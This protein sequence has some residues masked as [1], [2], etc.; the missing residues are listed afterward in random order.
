M[1]T[2]P[3]VLSRYRPLNSQAQPGGGDPTPLDPAA[4]TSWAYNPGNPYGNVGAPVGGE[5]GQYASTG[6]GTNAPVLNTDPN[7]DIHNM[8]YNDQAIEADANNKIS[9][10]AENQLNYYGPIQQKYQGAQDE[11]LSSLKQ[12]PG[13]TADEEAK[14]AGNPQAALDA[15]KSGVGHEQSALNDYGSRLGTQLDAYGDRV[16]EGEEVLQGGLDASQ[17]KFSSLDSAVNN[18]ALAFD[19]NG[20]EK[21]LSDADVQEMKTAAGTRVGNQYRNSEDQLRRNAAAAGNSSPLAIAAADE[22]LQ[23]SSAAGQGDAEV[24]A[25]IAARQAQMEQAKSIE[26]QREG[27]TQTQAGMKAQAATTEQAQAQS[28]AALSGTQRIA[29]GENVGAANVNAEHQFGQTSVG[30]QNTQT[31]Q[32]ASA[33]QAADTAGSQRA[34][35]AAQTRIGGQGAYRSGVA[36]QQGLAQQGGQTA[37]TQQQNAA[38]TLG[39]QLNTSTGNRANY[40]VGGQGNSAV[41]QATK[42]VGAVLKEGGIVTEPTLGVVGEAGPELVVPLPRY[43]RNERMAA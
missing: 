3:Q 13:Y 36:Q 9:R 22:R 17:G 30:Q 40:E 10:E 28:A 43:R 1:A 2:Q 15:T 7:Q 23:R 33:T 25:D 5:S 29:A 11:A 35:D 16:K 19:P 4:N 8:F 39:S 18:P 38:T 32:L 21:Q 14:I 12:T 24:N 37:V 6:A 20:T 31:G 34:E 42:M 41:S 26:Q 27:A